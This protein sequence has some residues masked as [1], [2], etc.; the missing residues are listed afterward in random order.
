M[1][2]QYQATALRSKDLIASVFDARQTEIPGR[3]YDPETLDLL[4]GVLD[5]VWAK[6]SKTQRQRLPRSMIAERL[7]A[8]AAKGQRDR[9]LL[10]SSALDG[11]E[12]T[13]ST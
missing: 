12:S 5:E 10:R 1:P 11:S 4:R 6:L 8:A 2:D 13:S 9:D 7:L 3:T